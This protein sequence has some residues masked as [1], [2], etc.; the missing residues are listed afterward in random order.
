MTKDEW[1]AMTTQEKLD[2]LFHKY[3]IKGNTFKHQGE[4]REVA[5]TNEIL[6]EVW[7]KE[8]CPHIVFFCLRHEVLECVPHYCPTCVVEQLKLN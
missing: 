3:P 7:D 6:Y 4:D 2:Y 1:E 8:G 5:S